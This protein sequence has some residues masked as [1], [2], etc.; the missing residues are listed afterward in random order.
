MV[1][2]LLWN[3]DHLTVS[4]SIDFPLPTERDAPF[5][6]AAFDPSHN[7][8]NGFCHSIRDAPFEGLL[9]MLHLRVY[10]T[11]VLLLI[12]LNFMIMQRLSAMYK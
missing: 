9:E 5:H 2:P 1:F 7:K 3:T 10:L 11:W 8:W 6:D 4:V 12:F